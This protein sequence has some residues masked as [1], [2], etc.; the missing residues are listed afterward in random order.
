MNGQTPDAYF[1][2]QGVLGVVLVCLAIAFIWYYK[3]S[4]K[5]I[6][7]LNKIIFQGQSDRLADSKENTKEVTTVLQENSQNLRILSEKIEIGKS[8]G[9]DNR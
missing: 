8:N 6:D 4:Q 1:F 2:T 3:N 7:D 9:R 5:K